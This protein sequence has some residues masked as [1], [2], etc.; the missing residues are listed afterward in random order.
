MN[1]SA[2][3]DLMATFVLV[4]GAFE[5]GWYWRPVMQRLRAAGHE[6]FAPSLT[7]LGERKHL[8]TPEV[9]LETHIADVLG[10]IRAEELDRV[11]LAGHSYGGMVITGTADRVPE[12]IA[13][14]VY[15]DA[16]VPEDGQAMFELVLEERRA[17]FI[18]AAE[19]AGDGW[20]VPPPPATAWGVTDPEIGAWLDRQC[21]DHP[22]STMTQPIRLTGAAIDR[23]HFVLAAQ[24]DPSPFQRYAAA[25]DGAPGWTVHRIDDGH[26]L[27][28]TQP[29]A[30]SEIL[31]AAA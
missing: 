25:L 20:R 18:A 16:F 12:R 2:G 17:G 3:G 7:G 9:D 5:S 28:V 1:R 31:L 26:M 19:S 30:V 6:V 24:Y 8:L 11:I 22:L 14:L 15:F 10:V 4:H 21:T 27:P 23:R 29:D 13:A